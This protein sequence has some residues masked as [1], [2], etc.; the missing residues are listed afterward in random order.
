MPRTASSYWDFEPQH[1]ASPVQLTVKVENPQ[2][3]RASADVLNKTGYRV[4][5]IQDGEAQIKHDK[6]KIDGNWAMT[7]D[8]Y[9]EYKLSWTL[10]CQNDSK[11]VG[12]LR[13]RGD[14]AVISLESAKRSVTLCV[15]KPGVAAFVSAWRFSKWKK[16]TS[17]NACARAWMLV[18]VSCLLVSVNFDI[19]M[20]C[21]AFERLQHVRSG[22]KPW[23]EPIENQAN[24]FDLVQH[25][26]AQVFDNTTIARCDLVSKGALQLT[27]INTSFG[28]SLSI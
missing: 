10:K 17:C 16:P 19:C 24:L 11:C 5:W 3:H 6:R 8:A 28:C 4:L 14:Y 27:F 9:L 13:P 7:K 26:A 18:F 25:C 15:V 23:Q 12:I 1:A 21:W 20:S 2:N 22:S